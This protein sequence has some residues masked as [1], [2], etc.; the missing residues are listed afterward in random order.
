MTFISKRSIKL[1]GGHILS[2]IHRCQDCRKKYERDGNI[3]EQILKWKTIEKDGYPKKGNKGTGPQIIFE[4]NGEF[5]G[6]L[7]GWYEEDIRDGH[8]W[9][10]FAGGSIGLT[11][12]GENGFSDKPI[13]RYAE[14]E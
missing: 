14:L 8:P 4:V 11:Y 13:I 3:D 2:N 5:I 7:S 6:F 9:R 12:P 1:N 10:F